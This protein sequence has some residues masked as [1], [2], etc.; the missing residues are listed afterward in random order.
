LAGQ[1]RAAISTIYGGGRSIYT[2]PGPVL[3]NGGGGDIGGAQ[4]MPVP[5]PKNPGCPK[6]GV[7]M[8]HA[9]FGGVVLRGT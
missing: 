5:P 6:F 1:R 7:G 2:I 9:R 8:P 4:L 3:T